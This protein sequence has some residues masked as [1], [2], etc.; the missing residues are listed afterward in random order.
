MPNTHPTANMVADPSN[1]T[2]N[3]EHPDWNM[4]SGTGREPN[5]DY[6]DARDLDEIYANAKSGE[7]TRRDA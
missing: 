4:A 5:S 1:H 6:V 2:E 3:P 7:Q